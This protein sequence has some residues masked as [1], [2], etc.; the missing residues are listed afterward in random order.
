MRDK[1]WMTINR[2]QLCVGDVVK[3]EAGMGI[4]V[5]GIVLEA[6]GVQVDESAMTGESDHLPRESFE[7]C[8]RKKT[9][10]EE[11]ATGANHHHD[12]PSCVLLSGTNLTTGEGKYVVIVVGEQSC[13]GK[14]Q[15]SLGDATEEKTPLQEM[16]NIIATDIGKLGMFCAILIF[17]ALVLR[18]FI[19]GMVRNDFDLFGGEAEEYLGKDCKLRQLTAP[20]YL[21]GAMYFYDE[22]DDTGVTQYEA[23]KVVNSDATNVF[24]YNIDGTLNPNLQD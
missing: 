9:I 1:N 17:H 15:A 12:V 2:D 3:I 13:E 5:D 21:S 22:L 20:G 14:I 19:E 16:L 6:S 11:G 7:V 4:P 18:N 24:L 8:M 23:W 10:H